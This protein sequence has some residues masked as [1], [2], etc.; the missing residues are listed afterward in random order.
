MDIR[1]R[2]LVYENQHVGAASWF[3]VIGGW[4]WDVRP[5]NSDEVVADALQCNLLRGHIPSGA[6]LIEGPIADLFRLSRAPVPHTLAAFA[7]EEPP[8]LG[9]TVSHQTNT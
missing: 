5:H 4:R 8:H 1:P 6:T 7:A 2:A 3:T 9:S